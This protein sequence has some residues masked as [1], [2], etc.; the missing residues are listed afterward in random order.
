[1]DESTRTI[2]SDESF[3]DTLMANIIDNLLGI[4]IFFFF[5]FFLKGTIVDNH[6]GKFIYDNIW[7]TDTY[8][9]ILTITCT[10]HPHMPTLVHTY[11]LK[12]THT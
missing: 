2:K 7:Y 10:L 4:T 8:I 3:K 1:M 12:F 9:Y 6:Y 5:F 11:I